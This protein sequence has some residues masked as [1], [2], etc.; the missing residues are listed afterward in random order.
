VSTLNLNNVSD[1][2]DI[3]KKAEFAIANTKE[4]FTPEEYSEVRKLMDAEL[5]DTR[6]QIDDQLQPIEEG[7]MKFS[8]AIE[9]LQLNIAK[10]ES[11]GSDMQD[12]WSCFQLVMGSNLVSVKLSTKGIFKMVTNV[13]NFNPWYWGVTIRDI[14]EAAFKNEVKDDREGAYDTNQIANQAMSQIRSKYPETKVSSGTTAASYSKPSTP[15]SYSKPATSPVTT[16]YQNTSNS[17]NTTPQ[18]PAKKEGCYIATAV[19]GSY[20][21]PQV[22]TL[23]R[24]RDDTLR[25]S[26][27]GRWFIRTYYRLSPPIAEKLK[28][29]KLIN[30]LVR[31]LLD[32]WVA[33]LNKKQ[34]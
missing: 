26:A 3:G 33:R 30:S 29:A 13:M 32:K 23:R 8:S 10:K 12:N 4:W 21:A 25:N 22:M 24:F 27:F 28:N 16:S 17:A 2:P 1:E 34:Q 14:W 6:K 11:D 31:S 5:A 15:S 18:Q 7:W 20:D 9:F 19:Y